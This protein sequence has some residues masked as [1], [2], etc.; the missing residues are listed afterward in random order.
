MGLSKITGNFV[1]KDLKRNWEESPDVI[2]LCLA[3]E[4]RISHFVTIHTE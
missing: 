4:Q 3:E 2:E 1:L